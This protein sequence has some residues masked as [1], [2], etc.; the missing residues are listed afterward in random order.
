MGMRRRFFLAILRH[1]KR[2]LHR[3]VTGPAAAADHAG[4]SGFGRRPGSVGVGIGRRQEGGVAGFLEPTGNTPLARFAKSIQ[5]GDFHGLR[6]LCFRHGRRASNTPRSTDP[7]E[8]EI[9][10]ESPL[11]SV[12]KAVSWRVLATL[13]TMVIAYIVIGDISDALKIGAVEVVAKMLIYYLRARFGT[14]SI[15]HRAPMDRGKEKLIL[16]VCQ[17]YFCWEGF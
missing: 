16:M 12:L 15:G 6:F 7:S 3:A 5:H 8:T 17:K 9:I 4:L 14:D 2:W 11:R 10:R 13:T 1:W